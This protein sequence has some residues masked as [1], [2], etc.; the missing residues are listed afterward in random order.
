MSSSRTTDSVVPG[1]PVRRLSWSRPTLRGIFLDTFAGYPCWIRFAYEQGLSR[2][3]HLLVQM[4]LR[5]LFLR[6]HVLA[7]G[8]AIDQMG[9]Q[10][11]AQG[12]VHR[13]AM[14]G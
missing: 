14:E 11:G 1:L 6:E 9:G 12:A 4:E 7:A 3:I 8:H 10:T 5:D 2:R 13:L